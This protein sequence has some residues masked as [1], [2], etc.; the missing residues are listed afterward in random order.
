MYEISHLERL[1]KAAYNSS[2]EDHHATDLDRSNGFAAKHGCRQ[3]FEDQVIIFS[4]LKT[5]PFPSFKIVVILLLFIL[6]L[7]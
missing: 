3:N 4:N 2:Q 7:D 5:F 1:C 6:L